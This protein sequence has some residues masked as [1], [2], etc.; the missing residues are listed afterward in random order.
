MHASSLDLDAAFL[1]VIDLQDR[2]YRTALQDWDAP[3]GRVCILIRAA[4]LL[5]M[6]VIYTEQYPKGLGPTAPE[7]VEA[8]GGD[9]TRFEKMTISALGAPGFADHL[10]VLGR[11]QVIVCGL[12]TH[13]CVSQTVHDLLDR[14][15]TVHVIADAVASR[16]S[17]DHEQA[18]AK[19]LRS[20]AIGGTVESV[21]L[22]CMRT[23]DHPAFKAVQTLIK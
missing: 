1:L 4:R 15:L 8:L 3:A 20:G 11:S 12:E 21:L 23:A 17:I 7:V 5:G 19:M 9:A 6:P 10:Q 18:L 14:G 2:S 13:A 22:E 16:H